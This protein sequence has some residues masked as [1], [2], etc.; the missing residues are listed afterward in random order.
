M[1][2]TFNWTN[3]S[4]FNG[5]TNVV[6]S[7]E[8]QISEINKILFQDG[9]GS[10]IPASVT[11]GNG[12]LYKKNGDNSIYWKTSD[13]E[14][15]LATGSPE[16]T[17]AT[18]VG[19]GEGVFSQ[20]SGTDL[21]FKSLTE[22]SNK[23]DLS[24]TATEI[25]I[26]VNEA[27]L[28]IATTQL[29][30]TLN[31]ATVAES[32][33]T[34]HE[35][36]INIGAGQVGSGTFA[37]ARIAE[38]NVTQHESALSVAATQLTGTLN[39]ATVAE[40][41]VTQHESALSVAATQLTGTLNNATVAESNV[42]QHEG[43]LSIGESQITFTNTYIKDDGTV[44]MAAALN[45]NGNIL[46]NVGTVQAVTGSNLNFSVGTGS[47]YIFPMGGASTFN[48]G[49]GTLT[50]DNLTQVATT[51]PMSVGGNLDLN[52]NNIIDVVNINGEAGSDTK[53][54]APNG[55]DLNL[56][57]SNGQVSINGGGTSFSVAASAVSSQGPLNM[58][59]NNITN[60]ATPTA[61]GHAAEYNW[62]RNCDN[63]IEWI[64]NN[65]NT[66]T[67]GFLPRGTNVNGYPVRY[68]FKHA[69]VLDGATILFDSE[70]S[71]WTSGIVRF[72]FY[73]GG[74]GTETGVLLHSATPV[75]GDLTLLNNGLHDDDTTPWNEWVYEVEAADLG[76]AIA[77]N[78]HIS[79]K[80]DGTS[81]SGI[82]GVEIVVQVHYRQP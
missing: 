80:V 26:D 14:E 64:K 58:N 56:V 73:K 37:D 27:N 68:R 61:S 78:E 54:E 77:A 75:P 52:G 69:C 11:A 34:Q 46:N 48:V 33:V 70:T 20:L 74:V 44:P 24:S 21:E 40:S 8:R 57:A 45:M 65:V 22:G 31:N 36:A 72:N 76:D 81:A 2:S 67:N 38:S 39:D 19:G 60:L 53:L 12:Y 25:A 49:G 29:T 15:T 16:S 47:D 63:Y 28:S 13:G 43:A 10:Q 79:V 9:D 62:V 41:N 59:S 42:T 30:G 7:D 66:S 82:S 3:S 55:Q 17:T 51:V 4:T 35:G 1:S 18:N 32:N 6:N 5:V 71:T 23:I 50:V